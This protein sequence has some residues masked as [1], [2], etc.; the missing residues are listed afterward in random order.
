KEELDAYLHRIE[1]AK[2]RDHRVVGKA[3]DLFMFH[4]YSPGAPFWT[5]KGTIV[6]NELVEFVRSRQREHFLEIKTPLL[7]NKA[8]WET[9][10]HC[11]KYGENIFLVVVKENAEK[12]VTPNPM[13]C[14][15]HN[16]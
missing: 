2:R 16:L 12:D 7:Y 11:G 9:S 13:N 5:E 10:G 3:L 6:Y 8:L 14:P 1:E 4:Q 15:S